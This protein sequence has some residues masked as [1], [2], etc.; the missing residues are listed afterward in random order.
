[1]LGTFYLHRDHGARDD[2]QKARLMWLV[3]AMGV[4][5]FRAAIEQRMG[6]ALRREVRWGRY[7]LN[8]KWVCLLAGVNAFR[9]AI[10]QRMG[11]RLRREVRR[12]CCS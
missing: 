10:E 6:Q 3:E 8:D 1:M 9:A 4:G 12:G 11:Q 5:A 7:Q 2:R